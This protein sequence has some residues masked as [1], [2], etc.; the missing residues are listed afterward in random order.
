[1]NLS[2]RNEKIV[3]EIKV[4]PLFYGEHTFEPAT[5]KYS[6]TNVEPA[7]RLLGTT[8]NKPSTAEVI[9]TREYKLSH[10]WHF[11]SH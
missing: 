1:M 3:R 11:V 8:T 6:L 5:Y 4:I 7:S 9:S 2:N 10:G